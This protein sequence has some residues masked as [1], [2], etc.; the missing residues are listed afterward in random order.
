MFAVW[1]SPLDAERILDDPGGSVAV[2]AVDRLLEKVGHGTPHSRGDQFITRALAASDIGQKT[3]RHAH[4]GRHI[5]TVRYPQLQH[6]DRD[7]DGDD[8]ITERSKSIFSHNRGILAG[9][10]REPPSAQAL[11]VSVLAFVGISAD[12]TL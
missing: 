7:Q 5:G 1:A 12:D 9:L 3:R 6:H 10:T 2:V 4:E 11:S 8:A